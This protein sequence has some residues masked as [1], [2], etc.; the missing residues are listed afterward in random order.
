MSVS[1][2]L[3]LVSQA[4]TTLLAF[5]MVLRIQTQVFISM[6]HTILAKS[7]PQPLWFCYKT[8]FADG[9]ESN[10]ADNCEV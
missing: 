6:Q 9:N 10:N 3:A 8:V 2:C 4:E 7:S 5:D 1:I